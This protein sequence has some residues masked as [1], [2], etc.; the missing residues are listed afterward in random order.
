MV[1]FLK[2]LRDRLFQQFLTEVRSQFWLTLH[3]LEISH[4]FTPY[5]EDQ[6]HATILG[7]EGI[8][9]GPNLINF[10]F[11]NNNGS[12]RAMN[13][14]GLLEFLGCL[15]QAR[16]PLFTIRVGGFPRSACTCTGVEL[17]D[18][19]CP[20]SEFHVFGRSAYQASFF[21]SGEPVMVTGWPV[22]SRADDAT[23]PRGL[24]GLRRAAEEFGF[25][26][27]V[28][29]SEKPDWK[30]D[31]WHFRLGT[32]K[33]ISPAQRGALEETMRDHLA[34]RRVIVDIHAADVNIV[35]YEQ[36]DLSRILQ[37]VPLLKAIQCPNL[38]CAMYGH[39]REL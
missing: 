9:L 10:N 34:A 13:V 39:V 32:L 30:D 7:L 31:D 35:L 5:K 1:V 24:Y 25:L 20:D 26:D 27:K 29:I 15:D 11:L 14:E 37:E 6:F 19:S 18:W 21:V 4:L 3:Q 8:R 28:H 22:T 12:M 38:V 23:F 2:D 16:S 33:V 36:R 17:R